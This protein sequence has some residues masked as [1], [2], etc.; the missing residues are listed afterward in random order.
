MAIG[1]LLSDQP[2]RRLKVWYHNAVE[3]WDE[4]C[5]RLDAPTE[6]WRDETPTRLQ[7][8]QKD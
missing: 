8:R 7:C 3:D 2:P 5:R 6:T 1:R 4:L